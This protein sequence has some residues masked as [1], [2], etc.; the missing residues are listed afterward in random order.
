MAVLV[1]C[2]E[3]GPTPE[4]SRDRRSLRRIRNR[5]RTRPDPKVAA[6]T[7]G[8][9]GLSRRRAA[10]PPRAAANSAS[11]GAPLATLP[12][13]ARLRGMSSR[14]VIANDFHLRKLVSPRAGR[15]RRSAWALR[16]DRGNT[17]WRGRRRICD[18]RRVTEDR[19]G[20]EPKRDRLFL[21]CPERSDDRSADHADRRLS[22]PRLRRL[23]KLRLSSAMRALR[24]V[25]PSSSRRTGGGDG[26]RSRLRDRRRMTTKRPDA[27]HAGLAISPPSPLAQEAFSAILV[28]V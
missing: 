20:W 13:R 17:P 15:R 8:V 10:S 9:R 1:D 27:S 18:V 11:G 3:E 14:S 4:R 25:D 5:D 24:P 6:Q 21:Q 16:E 23:R 22:A 12:P 19:S 28:W 2:D 26:G 7:H